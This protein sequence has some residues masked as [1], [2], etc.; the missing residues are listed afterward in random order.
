MKPALVVFGE[1]WHGLPS[2]TQHL[3]KALM[4]NYR[5]LWVNSIGLR[6]PTLS[7]R[8]FKRAA[9]K[10]LHRLSGASKPQTSEAQAQASVDVTT[11]NIL[12][13][14]APRS[15]VIRCLCAWAIA[16]QVRRELTKLGMHNPTLWLSLPTAGDACQ[17]I[18]HKALLYYCCDDFSSLAGVD[19]ATVEQHEKALV[20]AADHI[21]ISQASLQTKWPQKP[22]VLLPHGV[23]Y[24]LFSQPA[25]RASD[26]PNGGPI[27]GVYGSIASWLDQALLKKVASQLPNWQFVFVG[28]VEVDVSTLASLPN[29]HFLGPRPHDQL[30]RYSQH[31]DVAMLPFIQCDQIT[32]CN[33]LKLREYLAAGSPIVSTRFPA[34]EEYEPLVHIADNADAFSYA[35]GMQQQNRQ[36]RLRR[37]HAVERESWQ[38]RADVLAT[39]IG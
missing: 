21:V 28:K 14:P 30:P 8:D 31:W 20:N 32:H 22:A 16:W 18:P 11:L 19:H 3:V 2:S 38:A 25:P 33:P 34:A 1:D 15:R 36:A 35:L 13:W 27:A 37:M 12:T 23:D 7:L 24:A 4:R 17:L 26:L 39:L 10:V 5:I 6:R 9:T 29:V